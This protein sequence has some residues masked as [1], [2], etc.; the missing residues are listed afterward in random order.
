[1]R[2]Q[3]FR[4]SSLAA[5]PKLKCAR[6]LRIKAHENFRC[7][8]RRRKERTN[9]LFFH[10]KPEREAKTP[11]PV[12]F[13]HLLSPIRSVDNTDQQSSILMR[14][15]SGRKLK[16]IARS[17]NLSLSRV[18]TPN[19]CTC[20]RS[21]AR[22]LAWTTERRSKVNVPN[23]MSR[24][25][26][27]CII[28][29]LWIRDT[30]RERSR[31]QLALSRTSARQD[32]PYAACK[33]TAPSN[34]K[35]GDSRAVIRRDTARSLARTWSPISDVIPIPRFARCKCPRE[36]RRFQDF[37]LLS[38]APSSLTLRDHVASRRVAVVGAIRAHFLRVKECDGSADISLAADSG[39]AWDI[40]SGEWHR[41]WRHNRRIHIALLAGNLVATLSVN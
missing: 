15:V 17:C 4:I 28:H 2:K 24:T 36:S 32:A 10:T 14:K 19:L 27:R 33:E 37:V 3:Q 21:L 30:A 5:S 23:F 25:L 13:D 29:A 31:Q 12:N 8:W 16:I 39:S 40:A 6:D 1:M 22:S 11:V 18:S 20:S 26:P 35:P 34:N 9:F 41:E 7:R 38:R